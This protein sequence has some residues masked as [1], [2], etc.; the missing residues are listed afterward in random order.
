MVND[1]LR[2][3]KKGMLM[4]T[5]K[6]SSPTPTIHDKGVNGPDQSFLKPEGSYAGARRTRNRMG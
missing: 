6:V 2:P 3:L 5:Y 1:P 4:S